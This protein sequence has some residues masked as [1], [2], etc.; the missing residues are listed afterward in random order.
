MLLS[1]E[2]PLLPRLPASP[3]PGATEA[4]QASQ[5]GDKDTKRTQGG[6]IHPWQTLE[7]QG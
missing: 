2:Q 7:L 6:Q 5:N 3:L 1:S 4:P